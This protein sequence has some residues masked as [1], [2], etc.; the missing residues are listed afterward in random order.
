MRWLNNHFR[1]TFE[2]LEAR[3][4]PT[5]AI[6]SSG[7]L[8]VTGTQAHEI[9]KITQING[10]ISVSG[11]PIVV[12][13]SATSSV[14]ASQVK[15]VVVY[16][17]GG[18]DLID[19]RTSAAAAVTENSYIVADGGANDVFGGDG[20]NY[21]VA[22]PGGHNTLNGGP[23]TDYLAAGDATDVLNGS[24]GFDWYYRPINPS[25]P[26]VNGEQ[27]SDIKQGE[28]PSCQTNAALAEAVQQH[29]NFANTIRYVGNSTYTVA[30]YGGSVHERVTF[31]GWYNSEEPVPAAS[32]EFWTIL[33]YR[34]RMQDLKINPDRDYTEAQWDA[35]NRASHDRLYSVAD[36]IQTVTGHAA[37][38][39]SIGTAT[40]R[41]SQ[42][43]LA[44]GDYVI[45]SSAPGSG[46]NTTGIAYDHAYAVLSVY[47]QDGVWKVELYNP[48]GFDSANGLTIE[49]LSGS[50][51]TNKGFI[52][53]SWSQFSSTANFQG[54][55]MT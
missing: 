33:M 42:A 44:A 13:K 8:S 28:S 35:L 37:T 40:P 31:N 12:G 3:D 1:P 22:G 30:L 46:V 49:S 16:A 18:G 14:A 32:G 48:W 23:G 11:V 10:R 24:G 15:E 17:S 20:S 36:A 19:L 6:L 41:Q 55:T 29:F 45:A 25:D 26:F 2:V 53:L 50:A 4:L 43:A 5:T 47:Y 51:P 39:D 38:Y 21:I 27:V 9:L 34:A 7:I 54:I 52:T